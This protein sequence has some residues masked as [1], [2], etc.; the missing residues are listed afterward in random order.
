M[1]GHETAR[2]QAFRNA[3]PSLGQSLISAAGAKRSIHKGE[4]LQI[5]KRHRKC[6]LGVIQF[7]VET[8]QKQGAIGQPGYR[9]VKSL[10]QKLF[11]KLFLIVNVRLQANEPRGL[12]SRV[13]HGQGPRHHPAIG[14]ASRAGTIFDFK[15]LLLALQM[16]RDAAPQ[17][18]EIIRMNEHVP[19]AKVACDLF[20]SIA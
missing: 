14:A 3:L 7:S 4:A 6:G 16:S 8:V 20:V 12:P 2:W 17:H 19:I 18:A 15:M 10:K 13:P 9:I 11:V 1:S 5:D